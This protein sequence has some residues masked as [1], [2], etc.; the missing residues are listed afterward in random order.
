MFRTLCLKI[1][2]I[3]GSI[4]CVDFKLKS[5]L[6]VKLDGNFHARADH[7]WTWLEF[8]DLECI[9]IC[10]GLMI[11]YNN[12]LLLE[13]PEYIEH[14]YFLKGFCKK[15]WMNCGLASYLHLSDRTWIKII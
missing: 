3:L 14:H 5:L 6:G 12:S 11:F 4:S 9:L 2:F 7:K 10:F 1:I 8:G 15:T 13:K